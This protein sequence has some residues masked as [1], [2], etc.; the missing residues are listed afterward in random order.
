VDRLLQPFEDGK[1]PTQLMYIAWEELKRGIGDEDRKESAT[2]IMDSFTEQY[3]DL[4]DGGG[5]ASTI[6]EEDPTER[7]CM[8]MRG[9]R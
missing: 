7:N 9:F 2:Q 3:Q 5:E 6:I 1:L 4:R 8:S